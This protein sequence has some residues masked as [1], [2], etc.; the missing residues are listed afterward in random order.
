[1]KSAPCLLA[2]ALALVAGAHAAASPDES[3]SER[4]LAFLSAIARVPQQLLG[5]DPS[6]TAADACRPS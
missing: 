4:R 2:A 5:E 6:L 3:P 1:M